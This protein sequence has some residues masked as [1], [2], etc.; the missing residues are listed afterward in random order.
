MAQNGDIWR[1]PRRDDWWSPHRS[2]RPSAGFALLGVM[3]DSPADQA[4]QAALAGA[5]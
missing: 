1:N 4:Q 2:T 5:R 3:E